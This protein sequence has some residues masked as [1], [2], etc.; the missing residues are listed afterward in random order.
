MNQLCSSDRIEFTDSDG[1]RRYAMCDQNDETTP[2]YFDS[3]AVIRLIP[4][5]YQS[6]SRGFSLS[7]E[8]KGTQRA[9][10]C[11][12]QPEYVL[13]TFRSKSTHYAITSAKK[14]FQN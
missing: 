5:D 1:N 6:P 4:V 8:I 13:T 7:Y 2:I 3:D 9:G 10:R 11:K 12:Y 14:F